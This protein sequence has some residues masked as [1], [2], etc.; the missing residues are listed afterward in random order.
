M[1][2]AA[3]R[4]LRRV[5]G[6]FRRAGDRH[7]PARPQQRGRENR[8]RL[9]RGLRRGSRR[10][11]YHRRPRGQ[12]LRHHRATSARPGRCGGALER[13]IRQAGRGRSRRR[14]G[15]HPRAS[16]QPACPSRR[17]ARLPPTGERSAKATSIRFPT[18][19]RTLPVAHRARCG[20]C[21]KPTATSCCR[22]YPHEPARRPHPHLRAAEAARDAA[23]WSSPPDVSPT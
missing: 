5:S 17:P 1:E 19:S 15:V 2:C 4:L 22:G 21:S 11:P 3:P 10:G 13:G 23:P 9:A 7:G 18:R 8:L 16:P 12:S 14:R 20:R 6:S